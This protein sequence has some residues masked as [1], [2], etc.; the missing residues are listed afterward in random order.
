M[1]NL[2]QELN[3]LD[4][5]VYIG[6][7]LQAAVKAQHDAS[8]SQVNFIKEVGFT[9]AVPASGSG[10]TAVPATP[11]QLRYVDFNYQK[12]VPNPSYDPTVSGSK[13]FNES[14]VNL[15]VPFLTMLTI[16]ALRIDEMTID[17]NAKLNSVETQNVSSEFSGNAS[18]SAK[19]WKVKFNASASYKK[20]SSSTS[21]T[22]RTYTLGVHVKAVNDELPAGLSRIL[23]MLE[24]SI[25][26]V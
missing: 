13:P 19:F 17:F 4:F 8:I 23:D 14:S 11:A 18:L 26:A 5:S 24:D 15:K 12:S 10:S 22:E 21:T 9:P 16:P 20:T 25:A 7:P 1:A 2:V 6:G 3:S